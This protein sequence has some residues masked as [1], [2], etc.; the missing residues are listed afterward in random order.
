MTKGP[1][2]SIA[3]VYMWVVA[4]A[5][6][7]TSTIYNTEVCWS[8]PIC[9]V[10]IAALITGA[11]M[12]KESPSPVAILLI[13]MHVVFLLFSYLS[14]PCTT[15]TDVYVVYIHRVKCFKLFCKLSEISTLLVKSF[16]FF[17]SESY[18]V[19]LFALLYSGLKMFP[20][21]HA[22]LPSLSEHPKLNFCSCNLFLKKGYIVGGGGPPN[23]CIACRH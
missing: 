4:I 15:S 13:C 21:L 20:F 3:L 8:R 14:S 9:S 19:F 11:K 18:M 17:V 6:W 7:S 1:I 22:L 5:Y 23:F 12:E 2:Y 10:R 16:L